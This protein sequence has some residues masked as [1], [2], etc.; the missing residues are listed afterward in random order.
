MV[1]C[2][3]V[4]CKVPFLKQVI[5][6]SEDEKKLFAIQL[7]DDLLSI[8]EAHDLNQHMNSLG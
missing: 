5:Y 6:M 7:K 2:G 4:L 8:N 3:Q 1:I